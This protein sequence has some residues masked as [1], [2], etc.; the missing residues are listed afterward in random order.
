[1]SLGIHVYWATMVGL[2]VEQVF[3][4]VTLGACYGGMPKLGIALP[5]VETTLLLMD[6]SARRGELAPHTMLANLVRGFVGK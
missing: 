5:T 1:M 2:S 3:H 6:Q 4:V